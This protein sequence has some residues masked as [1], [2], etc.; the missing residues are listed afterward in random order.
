M[1]HQAKENIII[2]FRAM[3]ILKKVDSFLSRGCGRRTFF[4]GLA[5]ELGKIFA[6]VGTGC[7]LAK[8]VLAGLNRRQLRARKKGKIQLFLENFRIT[9]GISKLEMSV[10]TSEGVHGRIVGAVQS[11]QYSTGI[12]LLHK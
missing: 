1:A 12:S 2:T 4:C 11:C 8:R 3:P 5:L 10:I 9:L 7:G 6:S